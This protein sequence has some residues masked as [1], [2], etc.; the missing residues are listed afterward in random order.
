MMPPHV[1]ERIASS[2]GGGPPPEASSS[3]ALPEVPGATFGPG[4]VN[5]LDF[6]ELARESLTPMAYD[7]IAGGAC[8]ETTVRANRE[9]FKRWRF[10]PR[11]LVDVSRLSTRVELL[12]HPVSFPVL[13]APTAFH[14]LAH[15]DGEAATAR[16]AAAC[17]TLMVV[18]T[19]ANLSV[20]QVASG[21]PGAALWF[22]LY[23]HRD[24]GLTRELI[25]RAEAAGC[26]ALCLTVDTPFFGR[27]DRDM[28]NAF[29][30]PEGLVM[31]NLRDA[32]LDEA[33]AGLSGL[34]AY[35]RQLDPSL[36]WSAVD[37]LRSATRLPVVIKGILD[38]GD[39]AEAVRRGA[40]ALV[41]SNHGGRQLDGALATLDALPP[42]V[43]A[44]QGAVP[45]LMDGGVRRGTDV[46]KA[47]A[48][49]AR[50]VLVGR[51][52]L[53]GL[54]AGGQAGVERVLALLRAELEHAMALAGRPDVSRLDRGLL[55]P[56]PPRL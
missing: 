49:G 16:A 8:G 21:A 7:Y 43:D 24:R 20:T 48:L 39:A 13:V 44:L 27:R 50:A 36:D 55:V 40:A 42:V 56:A 45:V 46:L 5:V 12:G 11:V 25:E 2:V 15:P 23:I 19:I 38:P 51:P 28:R 54:A 6:E 22:Q 35:S 3:Q 18:S 52:V 9:A 17:G 41:V 14:Q 37:W 47:L 10:L 4:P 31:G 53:W 32:R 26:L 34:L 30:L 1:H 29:C 33:E